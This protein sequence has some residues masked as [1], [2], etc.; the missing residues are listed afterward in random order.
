MRLSYPISHGV[1]QDWD[2]IDKI[3]N[4][5]FTELKVNVK[6]TPFFLSEPPLNP[7]YQK[8]RTAE[9]FFET[10]ETPAFYMGI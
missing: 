9:I 1:I 6:E 2:A 5:I 10:Y 4:H 8:F 7:Y 3:W